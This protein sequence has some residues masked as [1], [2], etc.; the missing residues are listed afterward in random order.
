MDQALVDCLMYDDDSLMA[1]ALR[2]LDST[3]SQRDKLRTAIQ[4]VSLKAEGG[5]G[6]AS[7]GFTGRVRHHRGVS[8]ALQGEKREQE[9]TVRIIVTTS[10]PVPFRF[11]F[12][13]I[14]NRLNFLRHV[15]KVT[16][17]ESIKLPV[18]GDVHVLRC[19]LNELVS[20]ART[21]T[22]WGVKSTVSGDFNDGAFTDL[23]RMA[24]RL[25]YFLYAPSASPELGLQCAFDGVFE[26][27]DLDGVSYH[28]SGLWSTDV[29]E[30]WGRRTT[31]DLA[32]QRQHQDILRAFDVNTVLPHPLPLSV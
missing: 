14:I 20:L 26:G 30:K 1:S 9:R 4:E 21:T 10:T 23:M 24:D 7:L 19:E 8:R 6:E 17:L 18:Y 32:V 29:A 3:Y 25:L 12:P 31:A 13:K 11:F 5:Y 16:L 15:V 2:L 28:R 27:A 22:V